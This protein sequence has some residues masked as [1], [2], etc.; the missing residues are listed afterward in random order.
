M[1]ML[2]EPMLDAVLHQPVRTRLA[3]FLFTRGEATFTELKKQLEVTDGNLDAHMK[4]FIAAGYINQ[5]KASTGKRSTTSYS[6][7][8]KGQHAFEDYIETMK[9]VLSFTE[10][11]LK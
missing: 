9:R 2:S 11:K 10:I 7:T 4:K 1:D 5:T 8:E 6:L 3:A